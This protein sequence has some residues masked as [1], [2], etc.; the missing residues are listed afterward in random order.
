MHVYVIC[1][2]LSV[3]TCKIHSWCKK[4]KNKNVKTIQG[5]KKITYN[6]KENL[7]GSYTEVNPIIS[8]MYILRLD[9]AEILSIV[10][11]SSYI[12]YFS[13]SK[14]LWRKQLHH[15]LWC[16]PLLHVEQAVYPRCKLPWE[17]DFYPHVVPVF[18]GPNLE[19]FR[20]FQIVRLSKNS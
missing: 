18:C 8:L 9:L 20:T 4:K 3:R 16:L 15:Y 6:T 17:A 5:R 7:L 12:T 1:L 13:S 2:Y 14:E 11:I 10:D 19:P